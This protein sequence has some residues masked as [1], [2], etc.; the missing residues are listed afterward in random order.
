MPSQRGKRL[1]R[2]TTRVQHTTTGT[3]GKVLVTIIHKE[4]SIKGLKNYTWD[5]TEF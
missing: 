5:T 4:N 1:G 2:E 3:T